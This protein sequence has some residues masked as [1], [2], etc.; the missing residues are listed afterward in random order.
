MTEFLC[1]KKENTSTAVGYGTTV[2]I[3]PVTNSVGLVPI[4]VDDINCYAKIIQHNATTRVCLL[5]LNI[6]GKLADP[7]GDYT[8]G[9]IR[10]Q[11]IK[12]VH[13]TEDIF[14]KYLK[15]LATKNKAL[16]HIC[17][18]EMKDA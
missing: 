5:R 17:E 14:M 8:Q 12:F 9:S 10:N 18:R 6:Y 4:P 2:D 15:Y 16:L 3:D 13:T 1:K 7:W 11:D